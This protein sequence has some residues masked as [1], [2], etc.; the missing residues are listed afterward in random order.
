MNTEAKSQD[1]VKITSVYMAPGSAFNSQLSSVPQLGCFLFFFF[2]PGC[3][4]ASMFEHRGGEVHVKDGK[5]VSPKKNVNLKRRGWNFI[6]DSSPKDRC[7]QLV[8]KNHK[9]KNYFW[10][11]C[12]DEHCESF[13]IAHYLGKRRVFTGIQVPKFQQSCEIGGNLW[14]Q[15]FPSEQKVTNLEL[16]SSQSKTY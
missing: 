12:N 9:K 11:F 13:F 1:E 10:T 5:Y 15:H 4:K 6:V 8:S 2:F 3:M 16:W 7:F 14:C